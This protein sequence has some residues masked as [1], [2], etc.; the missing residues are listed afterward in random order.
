MAE[1]PFL[2]T[3]S[4]PSESFRCPAYN[5]EKPDLDVLMDFPNSYLYMQMKLYIAMKYR[6]PFLNTIYIMN[7]V[8][9][10]IDEKARPGLH[11]CIF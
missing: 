4:S 3:F 7:S 8:Y 5:G 11:T 9:L 1:F 6:Y 2:P 10:F